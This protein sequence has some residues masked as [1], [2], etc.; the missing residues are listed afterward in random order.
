MK[1]FNLFV[2]IWWKLLKLKKE[3]RNKQ[4]SYKNEKNYDFFLNSR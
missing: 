1:K 2:K 3:L 4:E